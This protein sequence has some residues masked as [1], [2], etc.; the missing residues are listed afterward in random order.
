MYHF[1][2]IIKN[3]FLD[4]IAAMSVEQ[5]VTSLL[6]SCILCLFIVVIY[7][8]TYSGTLFS[9]GFA[10]SLVLLGM[11]TSLVIL[12]VSTNVVL[13]LGMVGA[14]S[15]VR[16]RT[17]VKDPMD[18]VFMFWAIAVGIVVGA[19]YV[20]VPVI[21]TVLIGLLMLLS[22]FLG[23]KAGRANWLVV[24]RCADGHPETE[25]R[26]RALLPRCR[27]RSR[28]LRDGALEVV[29]EVRLTDGQIRQADAIRDLDGVEEVS[30]LSSTGTAGL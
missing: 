27:V 22:T 19:G 16:F 13:S 5:L 7:R 12:A 20:T 29:Y 3:K 15:I 14:L 18:T 9:R 26:A 6:L 28:T 30:F 11:V 17:A 10:V 2:D 8:I 21:A 24:L 25:E 23:K 1:S 4:E